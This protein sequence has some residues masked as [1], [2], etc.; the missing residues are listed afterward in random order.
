MTAFYDFFRKIKFK[1]SDNSNTA[2][3]LSPI[4]AEVAVEADSIIDSA[5]II[6]GQNISFTVNDGIDSSGG[7]FGPDGVP[8]EVFA[9]NQR[10]TLDTITINGPDY[11]MYVPLDSDV[12]STKIRLER[13]LGADAS[14][15]EFVAD[16]NSTITI[17]RTA[18]DQIKIGHTGPNL[19]YSQENIE[20]FAAS[21]L[22]N[23]THTEITVNYDDDIEIPDFVTQDDITSV[24][25]TPGSGATFRVSII[26]GQ[27]IVL[28]EEVGVNYNVGDVITIDGTT[29]GGATPANDITLTVTEIGTIDLIDPQTDVP[30]MYVS[31]T[32]TPPPGDNID[33]AVTSTLENVTGRGQISTYSTTSNKIFITDNT[34]SS[35]TTTG[36]LKV[37]GGVGIAG[38][39]YAGSVNTGNGTI[40]GQY[41][42]NV[43]AI[44]NGGASVT[45][46]WNNGTVQT[47][48]ADSAFGLNL[49]TNMPTGASMT[50]I[51]TQDGGGSKVMTP[52][53]AYRFA[54]GFKTLSTTAGTVDMLNIFNP[55]TGVYLAA[56]TTGYVA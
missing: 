7:P 25:S 4:L 11:Q 24:D 26:N 48:T 9:E 5:T 50:L 10:F 15:I 2:P 29:I 28:V 32:G 54:F 52:N 42:E 3:H 40:T 35:N 41:I 30:Y 8:G 14:E 1:P 13:D 47:I 44:G 51:I 31:A 27:Y 17:F 22:I 53:G 23:G 21:L 46:N 45:P 16:P 19:P 20:D 6:A 49:P 18:D 56:L 39:V 38:A 36:A 12:R 34:S 33:L 43:H 37:T 55:G